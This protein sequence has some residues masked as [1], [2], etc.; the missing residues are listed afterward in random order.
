[1]AEGEEEAARPRP[2]RVVEALRCRIVQAV[3]ENRVTIIVG[4]TGCGKSSMI[5]QFLLEENLEPIMCTLPRRFA[6]VALA[7]MVARSRNWELGE[8][9]GYHIGHSNMTNLISTRSK[10]VFKTAG[11]VLEQM[12]H[13]GFAALQYKVIILDEIHER[14]VESDLVLAYVKQFMMTTN[15]S[16]LVLTSATIDSTQYVEYFK[17]IGKVELI[18]IP[19][20][21]CSN[22]QR[23]V[24]YLE[25]IVDILKMDSE[26]ESPRTKYCPGLDCKAEAYLSPDVYQLIN[27]LLLHIHESERDTEKG[28]L[29]FLPTYYALEQQWDVLSGCSIFKIHILHRSIDT[30]EALETMKAS[31]S[32]RKVILATNM[33]ES[34]VT[35]PGVAYVIDSCRSLQVYWNPV[36]RINSVKLVWISKSQAEQRKGRTGRTCDGQIFRLVTEPFYNTFPDHESPAIL[37]LSIR[38][39]ALMIC[40]AESRAM[41]DPT[42]LLQKILNPPESAVIKDALETLVQ[43]DAVQPALS[44]GYQPS[45]Y[46]YLLNSLP[47]SFHASVLTLKFGE[48]GYLHEGILIGIML[49][50]QPL[51]IL[52]P[53]GDQAL[54]KKIRD[55][56]FDEGSS[57]QIG[58]KEATLIGNL[59]AFQFWQYM[60]KDKFRLEYL[61]NIAKNEESNASGPL[62]LKN[63]EDWCRFHNLVPK[64]VN[65]ISEIYDDI[66]STLHRFRPPFL[67]K[68][69]P[70]KY[71]Q[72]SD[73]HHACRDPELPEPEHMPSF[74]LEAD[75]SRLDSQWRCASHPYISAT[76][77]G[78]TDIVNDLKKAIKE[79]KIQLADEQ[80][81]GNAQP[82][83]GGEKW[84]EYVDKTFDIL[85]DDPK[86]A[87]KFFLTL[88]GC[89]K[90]SSCSFPHDCDSLIS[91]SVGSEIN[92]EELPWRADIGW[93][94]LLTR[95]ENGHIL[96]VN[97]KNLKFSH[98][99]RKIV[100]R[101]P[102]LHSAEHNSVA[103]NLSIVL[104]VADPSHLT[105]GGEHELPVPWTKL[106]R[107]ILLDDYG[108]G[109]AINHQLLQK[110]FEYIAFKILPETLSGLQVILIMNNTKFIKIQVE[111][112]AR[113]CFFFLGESFLL[114]GVPLGWFPCIR[115]QDGRV[116][117]PVAYVFNMHPPSP[118]RFCNREL[119]AKSSAETS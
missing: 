67:Q 113:E 60:F 9:V 52:Q 21:S 62:I 93:T 117:G 82:A 101:T 43:I 26:T 36:R 84:V 105:I 107:I 111:R 69:S 66:M 33:A 25:Q 2:T 72:T 90:G 95:G 65:N 39:Q 37:S 63:E 80:V 58:K 13:K 88:K 31:K 112:M 41:N 55:H 75:N 18:T 77:F 10:I 51:P 99:L 92:P 16:R 12:R 102:D 44:G 11:V 94:K 119:S 83:F 76:D 59:R 1:M 81:G 48:M 73:F 47:L 20:S 104:N 50:I 64:A 53:F 71:L 35:I 29:V 24:Q 91:S 42:V 116:A 110:F 97:D 8:E 57:Q 85:A 106:Q 86:P 7:Q 34:S 100:A 46:G 56:Y 114:N 19:S 15:D 61:I 22:F 28:I 6:V 89:I 78:A 40:C 14:S 103:N 54:R 49:D 118:W 3:K 45:F 27:K 87:C 38:E 74:S 98:E 79:M 4:G 109:E 32:C 96:V 30:D 68:I 115:Q 23:K 70:P 5:P 17:D 108:S